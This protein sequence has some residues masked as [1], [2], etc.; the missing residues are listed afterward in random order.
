MSLSIGIIGL[1]NVGKSTTFNALTRTQNAQVANYPFCTI[2]PN[3]AVVPV[4]DP[5]LDHLQELLGVP[6]TLHA[7]IEFVDIAGLVQGASRGEGLGNQFLGNIREADAIAHVVRCFSDPNVVH[8]GGEPEPRRD[9]EIINVELIL[10]DLQQ[11]EGKLERLEGQVRG[12]RRTFL[13]LQQRALELKEHLEAGQ[14][15]RTLLPGAD[16][17]LLTL[18]REMRF[19]TAKPVIYVVNVDE[20]ALGEAPGDAPDCLLIVRAIAAAEEAEV[21]VLSAQLEQEMAALDDEERRAFLQLSGVQESGLQQVIR[22]SYE[23][24]GLLSFFT[25][26]ENETRAWTVRRGSTAPQAAGV[27]HTDFE[28]GFIRAEV[29][30]YETFAAQGSAAAAR[31]AGKMQLEGRDYV[32]QDGDIIHFRFNV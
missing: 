31:A 7:T 19:L 5:R 14:P 25:H 3:K 8:I 6:N 32:V 22:R 27:I 11:L 12:D 30:P 1:P 17:A 24:L 10:A 28:R 4:P 23:M 20:E 16:D 9:I 13:P 18:N 2:E 21:I 15:I 29:I 26:N